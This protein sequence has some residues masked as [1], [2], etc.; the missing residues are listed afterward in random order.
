M[1][2]YQ[3]T[4]HVVIIQSRVQ[5]GLMVRAVVIQ[6]SSS[7]WVKFPRR[8]D[9]RLCHEPDRSAPR[10]TLTWDGGITLEPPVL[11]P[12][13]W[14]RRS[15]AQWPRALQ[16]SLSLPFALGSWLETWPLF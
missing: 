9:L 10:G 11:S 3:V 16:I 13:T 2:A 8:S 15:S 1:K 4:I 14:R 12:W 7:S 5:E 6:S